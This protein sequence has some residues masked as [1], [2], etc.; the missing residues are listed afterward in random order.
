MDSEDEIDNDSLHNGELSE[1]ELEMLYTGNC[2]FLHNH[3]INLFVILIF[4]LSK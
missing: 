1:E 4:E 3:K 2:M